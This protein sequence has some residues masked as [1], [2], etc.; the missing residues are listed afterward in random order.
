MKKEDEKDSGKSL[1]GSL[2]PAYGMMTGQGLFGQGMGIIPEIAKRLRKDSDYLRG[3]GEV[4][5]KETSPKMKKGGKVKKKSGG[6][7]S[8]ASKRGDG[9]AKSGKT[10]CKIC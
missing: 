8:K 2:S 6:V 4:L 5:E 7:I 10:R 9:I 1:L 3:E